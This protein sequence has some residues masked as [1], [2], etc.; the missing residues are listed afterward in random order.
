M[1]KIKAK[2]DDYEIRFSNWVMMMIDIIKPSVLAFIGGRGTAKSTEILAKRSIDVVQDMPRAPLAFVADTYV[3]LMTNII[4]SVMLGWE[5]LKFFEGM[6]FV[7]DVK[8]P[9]NWQKPFIKTF[10]YKHTISTYNGCKFFLIS[11]DRPSNSAG[12]S[13]VHHFID[14]AKYT[15]EKKVNKLFPTLRGD[16]K[17][18]GHSHYYLGQTFCSDQPNPNIGEYDWML[19]FANKMNVDQIKLIIQVAIIVNELTIELINAEADGLPTLN[20]ERNIQRWSERL[21]KVRQDSILFYEVSSF[22]NVDIL[23]LKYF[24]RIL[25]SFGIEEFKVAICS[26]RPQLS[27]DTRFYINL[28]DDLFYSDGYD[29]DWYDQFGLRDNIKQT[30]KGL[31]YCN[32]NAILEA[33][34]DAGNMLSFVVGQEQGNIMRILKNFYTLPPEHYKELAEKIKTFFKPH[35]KKVIHVYADRSTNQYKKVKEDIKSKFKFAMENDLTPDGKIIKSGWTIIFPETSGAN[36]FHMQEYVLMYE[37]MGRKNPNLP[38]LLIDKHECKE[39]KSSL[40]KAPQKKDSKT[41]DIKKVKTSEQLPAHRLPM[42]STN[43]SDA[44][45][46]LICRSKWLA[47]SSYKRSSYIGSPKLRGGKV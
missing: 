20:I 17:L 30:S 14:E 37:I 13:V 1:K 28:N 16:A 44:F 10:D 23:T 47:I 3:N 25:N 26:F 46:Y 45:K 12:I 42:E 21:K 9:E 40:E 22:A 2:D 27:K 35:N 41:G 4:P 36:I 19:Q 8:P 7:A 31:K 33:G 24:L 6:H 34:W 38:I 18:Y 39:L 32:P 43:F 5:R 15:V 29:Y 11:L